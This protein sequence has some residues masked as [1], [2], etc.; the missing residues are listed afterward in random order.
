MAYRSMVT[1]E[2]TNLLLV[3]APFAE[4][5]TSQVRQY[6]QADHSIKF[7]FEHIPDDDI[8]TYMKAADIVVLPYRSVLTS[9][10][11][12]LA[13]SFGKPILAS[14]KGCLAE[15]LD[16]QGTFCSTQSKRAAYN[17]SWKRVR[18]AE[19]ASVRWGNET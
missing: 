10:A 15:D 6:A 5:Y 1:A 16:S 12:L 7:R 3:G 14:R 2:S 9:G 19:P 17:L 4:T 11:A 8:Q 18:A 13:M